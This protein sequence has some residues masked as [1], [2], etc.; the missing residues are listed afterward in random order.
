MT[1]EMRNTGYG[2]PGTVHRIRHTENGVRYI[3]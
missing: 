3:V 1:Y 2:A